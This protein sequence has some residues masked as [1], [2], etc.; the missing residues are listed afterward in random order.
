MLLLILE[1]YRNG[2]LVSSVGN[3][4]K[5]HGAI[6]KCVQNFSRETWNEKTTWSPYV[7]I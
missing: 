5:A 6:E 1:I 7:R 2:I 4:K 3:K